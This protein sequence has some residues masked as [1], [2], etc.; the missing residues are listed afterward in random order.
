MTISGGG[1]LTLPPFFNLHTFE[2]IGSTNVE[3][4]RLA[5]EGALE[6][7]LIWSLA[8]EQGV[9]RR[10]RGWSSPKGNLYCS[11]LLRPDCSA[12]E[13]AK[14]SFLIAVALHKA[15]SQFL[16]VGT[17]IALKWPNDILI[18]RQKLAGIL[19]ES[20]S[21]ANGDLDWLVVGTGVNIATYPKV[22]DGLNATSLKKE[23]GSI[24]VERVLESYAFNFLEL[25]TLWKSQGFDPIRKEWLS[26]ATGLGSSI[27]VKL[28][29][30]EFGGTFTDLD[31][32][33]ALVLTLDDGTVKYITAGEVFFSAP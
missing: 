25:Y 14:L 24:I 13:G 28:A 8:Q 31:A 2:T 29:E 11:L 6:G 1:G 19:L 3:A 5:E 32:N 15:L 27:I 22:T 12:V 16:P 4:R 33:G 26:R 10:G 20:K 21:N 30:Q 7:Q 18:R 9:G 23:G 17:D